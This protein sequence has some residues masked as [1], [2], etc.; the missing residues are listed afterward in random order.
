MSYSKKYYSTNRAYEGVQK[1]PKFVNQTVDSVFFKLINIPNIEL[2]KIKKDIDSNQWNIIPS[3]SNLTVPKHVDVVDVE[4]GFTLP[5]GTSTN[6]TYYDFQEVNLYE[7]TYGDPTHFTLGSVPSDLQSFNSNIIDFHFLKPLYWRDEQGIVSRIDEGYAALIDGESWFDQKV[8]IYNKT[9]L[10]YSGNLPSSFQDI[11]HSF[12]DEWVEL[13]ENDT[14]TIDKIAVKNVKL[15]YVDDQTTLTEGIDYH[16]EDTKNKVIKVHSP[17]NK[18][19]LVVEYEYAPDTKLH[20]ISYLFDRHNVLTTSPGANIYFYLSHSDEARSVQF[21]AGQGIDN[22]LPLNGNVVLIK[23]QFAPIGEKVKGTFTVEKTWRR[24]NWDMVQWQEQVEDSMGNLHTMWTAYCPIGEDVPSL[25]KVLVN[26]N[27][28]HVFEASGPVMG[29]DNV[30]SIVFDGSGIAAWID[31]NTLR[32]A[33]LSPYP[34]ADVEAKYSKVITSPGAGEKIVDSGVT[35]TQGDITLKYGTLLSLNSLNLYTHENS[36]G[37]AIQLDQSI[38][39]TNTLMTADESHTHKSIA[40]YP[41][42]KHIVEEDFIDSV[43]SINAPNKI[44]TISSGLAKDGGSLEFYTTTG[45]IHER[46]TIENKSGYTYTYPQSIRRYNDCI[47]VLLQCQKPGSGDQDVFDF[48]IRK[49]DINDYSYFDFDKLWSDD[50]ITDS[51][52]EVWSFT[53]TDE[54]NFIAI[55]SHNNQKFIKPLYNYVVRTA[56]VHDDNDAEL[57]DGLWFRRIPANPDDT[58]PDYWTQDEDLLWD[59]FITEQAVDHWGRIIGTDRWPKESLKEYTTRITN[60]ASSAIGVNKQGAVDGLSA[61]LGLTPYDAN[62]NYNINSSLPISVVDKAINTTWVI[63]EDYSGEITNQ[64]DGLPMVYDVTEYVDLPTLYNDLGPEIVKGNY[65]ISFWDTLTEGSLTW[66]STNNTLDLDVPTTGVDYHVFKYKLENHLLNANEWY[67]VVYT[68]SNYESGQVRL[69]SSVNDLTINY[70]HNNYSNDIIVYDRFGEKRQGNGTFT[71]YIKADNSG[72]DAASQRFTSNFGFILEEDPNN[73]ANCKMSIGD[74][75]IYKVN[76]L[77]SAL[78]SSGNLKLIDLVTNTEVEPL[79]FITMNAS[80]PLAEQYTRVLLTDTAAVTDVDEDG[81]A[82]NNPGDIPRTRPIQV[83]YTPSIPSFKLESNLVGKNDNYIESKIYMNI[84][85]PNDP[86]TTNGF[87][88]PSFEDSSGNHTNILDSV[89][90]AGDVYNSLKQ[91]PHALILEST[92]SGK[93]LTYDTAEQDEDRIIS[94]IFSEPTNSTNLTEPYGIWLGLPGVSALAI[95]YR[96]ERYNED[97]SSWDDVNYTQI[98]NDNTWFNSEEEY[99]IELIINFRPNESS[100][101]S[102]LNSWY[103]AGKKETIKIS[104]RITN[105]R[106]GYTHLII[107]PSS[108]MP[109][110]DKINWYDSNNGTVVLSDPISKVFIGGHRNIP[111][112]NFPGYIGKTKGWIHYNAPATI[113]ATQLDTGGYNVEDGILW[114]HEPGNDRMLYSNLHEYWDQ[115]GPWTGSSTT[116]AM[117]H[118][119]NTKMYPDLILK[120]ISPSY[121]LEPGIISFTDGSS[122]NNNLTYPGSNLEE[123]NKIHI[124]YYTQNMNILDAGFDSFNLYSDTL[125]IGG[126]GVTIKADQVEIVSLLDVVETT[127]GIKNIPSEYQDIAAE[128]SNDL[129]FKWDKFKWDRYR[130]ADGENIK[131]GIPTYYDSVTEMGGSCSKE[132]NGEAAPEFKTQLECEYADGYTWSTTSNNNFTSGSVSNSLQLISDPKIETDNIV[133]NSG[134]LYYEDRKYFLYPDLPEVEPILDAH[135]P[136]GQALSNTPKPTGPLS[137]RFPG[138]ELFIQDLITGSNAFQGGCTSAGT[139]GYIAFGSEK[140]TNGNFDAERAKTTLLDIDFNTKGPEIFTTLQQPNNDPSDALAFD[141][142]TSTGSGANTVWTLEN[143]G[144]SWQGCEMPDADLFTPVLGKTYVVSIDYKL[145]SGAEDLDISLGSGAVGSSMTMTHLNDTTYKLVQ[146]PNDQAQGNFTTIVISMSVYRLTHD[147]RLVFQANQPGEWQIKNISIREVFT[148]EIDPGVNNTYAPGTGTEVH[149][150]YV[151]NT[152]SS[153]LTTGGITINNFG[154]AN[155]TSQFSSKDNALEVNQYY[156]LE[157]EV[158][159]DTPTGSLTLPYGIGAHAII[160]LDDRELDSGN[161]W[162]NGNGANLAAYDGV[163]TTWTQD[164]NSIWWLKDTG[165]TS[166]SIKLDTS[167]VNDLSAGKEYAVKFTL[168]NLSSADDKVYLKF[169]NAAGTDDLIEYRAYAAGINIIKFTAGQ[170]SEGF[171]VYLG[172][173]TSEHGFADNS[174]LSCELKRIVLREIPTLKELP[175]TYGV[176]KVSF[177]TTTGN[178]TFWTNAIQE[179]VGSKLFIRNKPTVSTNLT[180]DNVKLYKLTNWADHNL[181]EELSEAMTS[182]RVNATVGNRTGYM[183][184]VSTGAG[185]QANKGIINTNI[186]VIAGLVY[187]FSVDV[188]VPSGSGVKVNPS[189]DKFAG[190]YLVTG[191]SAITDEW[192]TLEIFAYCTT[193]GTATLSILST[194]ADEEFWIDN[195]SVKQVSPPQGLEDEILIYESETTCEEDG[196]CLFNDGDDNY[197]H[198]LT[199]AQCAAFGVGSGY[200]VSWVGYTWVVPSEYED[201]LEGPVLKEQYDS[202]NKRSALLRNINNLDDFDSYNGRDDS[203]LEIARN[204]EKEYDGNTEWK[205]HFFYVSKNDIVDNNLDLPT[206]H[207]DSS[208]TSEFSLRYSLADS[209]E[210][211]TGINIDKTLDAHGKLLVIGKTTPVLSELKATADKPA[212]TRDDVEIILNIDLLDTEGAGIPDYTIELIINASNED[213]YYP[214]LITNRIGHVTVPIDISMYGVDAGENMTITLKALSLDNANSYIEKIIT[215]SK[216]N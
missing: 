77:S 44:A 101:Q 158:T 113:V 90:F 105:L 120:A 93:L 121:G 189:T 13:D 125:S 175:S 185:A 201:S 23:E 73:S 107:P 72:L 64:A 35:Y 69:T 51:L 139:H 149:T 145:V 179:D 91:D 150:P 211:D 132:S 46:V 22:M 171:R 181:N 152:D 57:F 208:V 177:K 127:N 174:P 119:P 75:K 191:N 200:Q 209:E 8:N 21:E 74:I 205:K 47:Y 160:D 95:R 142:F 65:G 18:K 124:Q 195:V 68:I 117:S 162:I 52:T 137:A 67:K 42:T 108:S 81:T 62:L 66:N 153:G 123:L 5:E 24:N 103:D 156:E 54:N 159:D 33:A 17:W 29:P 82:G 198:G 134:D 32:I 126:E 116:V 3:S 154:V 111:D 45:V 213:Y 130:W 155:L 38:G 143:T 53:I 50:L 207:T 199:N 78:A 182:E 202:Y 147:M 204:Y 99:K 166:D 39:S 36:P 146:D 71:D 84:S 172:S 14:Y 15:I 180:I 37:N 214:S 79:D 118:C 49:Y 122:S 129:E 6:G 115:E 94:G 76:S 43:V 206:V 19:A 48:Y 216:I 10:V 40:Y 112:T 58:I 187:K 92:I 80:G 104:A 98:L 26:G 170:L 27:E 100:E 106:T 114:E 140:I 109:T 97:T 203:I 161:N 183:W 7:F 215:L 128:L 178:D 167:Y 55:S 85:N 188:F 148:D 173:A 184:H 89:A 136:G 168:A 1:L 133:L 87:A 4:A 164:T 83:T 210:L 151:L 41:Y 70:A 169:T 63:N 190:S 12:E 9:E 141:T 86:F 138:N 59:R 11:S 30:D 193:G 194:S 96:Y 157:Y 110:D 131:T 60:V 197:L 186:N 192:Q 2:D 212:L 176:H 163:I 34:G 31:G 28:I 16:F 20:S 135:E 25:N 102:Y 56:P 88:A 61:L 144:T 196:R 165:T